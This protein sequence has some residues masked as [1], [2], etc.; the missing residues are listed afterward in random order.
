MLF[1]AFVVDFGIADYFGLPIPKAVGGWAWGFGMAFVV[2]KL[3]SW[4]NR[5]R[6][7]IIPVSLRVKVKGVP[8]VEKRVIR[9]KEDKK[10]PQAKE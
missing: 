7:R 9:A 6:W 3:V 8:T 5:R 1:V 2:P 4:G 10:K